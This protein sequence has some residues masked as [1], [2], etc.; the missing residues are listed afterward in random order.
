MEQSVIQELSNKLN[1]LVEQANEL[2]AQIESSDSVSFTRQHV[3]ALLILAVRAGRK[4]VFNQLPHERFSPEVTVEVGGDGHYFDLDI[5]QWVR[6]AMRA[7]VG[8]GI[9]DEDALDVLESSDIWN[10]EE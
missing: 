10:I 6:D 3:Q 7:N 8:E 2:K 4:T 5:T 9:S 1:T